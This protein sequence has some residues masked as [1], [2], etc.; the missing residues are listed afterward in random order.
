MFLHHSRLFVV[1]VVVFFL[2]TQVTLSYFIGYLY[3]KKNYFD[4]DNFKMLLLYVGIN[5]R[6]KL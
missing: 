1:V 2:P 6:V 3:D 4:D 5:R